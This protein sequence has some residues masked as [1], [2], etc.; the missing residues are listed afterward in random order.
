[1]KTIIPLLLICLTTLASCGLLRHN[2]EEKKQPKITGPKIAFS[3]RDSNEINQIYV[4]KLD[5][6]HLRQ[7]TRE[8]K[9]KGPAGAIS[10]AW[11]P[12]GQKIV[13]SS[14]ENSGSISDAGLKVMNADGS[15]KHWLLKRKLSDG[16]TIPLWGNHARWSPDGTKIAYD[17]CTNCELGGVNA[18]ILYVDVGKKKN[19]ARVYEV[20]RSPFDDIYPTWSP[21]GK[22]I[23]FASN[24]DYVHA[25]SARYRK[26]LYVINLDGTNLRRLTHTGHATQPKWGPEGN[27][28]AYDW[29]IHGNTACII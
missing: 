22:K 27:K 12:D 7:L 10:P 11:S 5:G 2:D 18:E 19:S 26:D 28:I 4:M 17:R 1:M 13:Y 23:A 20:T 25:D 16:T 29:N 9:G 3:A 21:D 24:R 15:D 8:G 6:S 14:Y